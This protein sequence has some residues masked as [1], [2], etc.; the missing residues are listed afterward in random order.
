MSPEESPNQNM[1]VNQCHEL[2]YQRVLSNIIY[3]YIYINECLQIVYCVRLR[4]V[5]MENLCVLLKNGESHG[6][7]HGPPN[8][9]KHKFLG[10][11]GFHIIIHI[12]INY[13]T[14]MI[15]AIH[16]I[17][18]NYSFP[19]VSKNKSTLAHHHP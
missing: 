2:K 17:Q 15:L 3:I 18:W 7:V 19:I 10:K 16:N 1:N 11:I 5:G 12:F 13:F 8:S 6:T 9:A 4:S 14:T